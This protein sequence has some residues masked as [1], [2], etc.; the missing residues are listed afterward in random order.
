M[1]GNT[2]QVMQDALRVMEVSHRRAVMQQR[3]LR[4]Q[5]HDP[6]VADA[7]TKRTWSTIRAFCHETGLPL[8]E[9]LT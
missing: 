5:R 4:R 3:L 9:E 8:P 7:E 1:S 2:K 6:W